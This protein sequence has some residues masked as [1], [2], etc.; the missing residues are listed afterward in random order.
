MRTIRRLLIAA[1]VCAVALTS[2][3]GAGEGKS[4]DDIS[5]ATMADSLSFYYGQLYARD[6]WL[7]AGRDTTFA[8]DKARTEYIK[9]LRKGLSMMSGDKAYDEGLVLGMQLAMNMRQFEETYGVKLSDGV[10]ANSVAYGLRNDSTVDSMEVQ[11]QIGQLMT[12][13]EREKDAREQ[14]AADKE[15]AATAKSLG[16]KALNEHLYGK[17]INAGKGA[18]LAKGTVVDVKIDMTAADSRKPLDIPMPS[19]IEVGTQ[20][21]NMPVGQALMSMTPG[22]TAQFATTGHALFGPRCAQM[23]IE[24]TQVVLIDITAD[25]AKAAVEPAAAKAASAT[26]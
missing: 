5:G 21:A 11:R 15:L 25:V 10:M 6:Y 26:K 22:E 24:P 9:G 17:V 14:A 8:T 2:C 3:G 7:A 1:G 4:L 23:R 13:L 18:R 16:M 19:Q 12:V 20:F